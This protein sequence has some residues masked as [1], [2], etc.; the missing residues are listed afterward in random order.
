MLQCAHAFGMAQP[1]AQCTVGPA[2]SSRASVAAGDLKGKSV[3]AALERQS[4]GHKPRFRVYARGA[5]SL[6]LGEILLET[7]D[8]SESQLSAALAARRVSGRRIG[9]ELIA[10]GCL[11]A[12][13]LASALKLQRRLAIFAIAAALIPMQREAHADQARAQMSVSATVVDTVSVR[14]MYQAQ[15][16]VVSAEDVRRG[17]IDV[18][19]GSRFSIRCASLCLFDF[20]PVGQLFKSVRVSGLDSAAEFGAA[21]ATLLHKPAPGA[22]ADV[23]INYRFTLSANVTPGAYPW[24]VALSVM[25][26]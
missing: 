13:R 20:R 23:A 2:A 6:R 12:E 14:S 3:T 11:R 4:S 21:G 16:L 8:I 25:P 9:E 10:A 24:P 17:Y 1:Y 5:V 7:G 15:Q 19:A 18:A 22:P 26:M